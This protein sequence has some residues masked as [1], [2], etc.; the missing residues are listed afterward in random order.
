[1]ISD[2]DLKD[3][4]KEPKKMNEYCYQVSKTRSIWVYAIDEE[5]AEV[6]IYEELGYD[7]DDMQLIEVL[8]DR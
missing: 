1:M 4:I 7:P 8:E 3:W 5:A 2:V 6:M